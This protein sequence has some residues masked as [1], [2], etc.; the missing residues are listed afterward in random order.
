[1]Y[2]ELKNFVV[3]LSFIRML[4]AAGFP[5]FLYR[6]NRITCQFLHFVYVPYFLSVVLHQ[7]NY[8]IK[9]N[10]KEGSATEQ[11]YYQIFV[12]IRQRQSII[13][14]ILNYLT[15]PYTCLVFLQLLIGGSMAWKGQMEDVIITFLLTQN[16]FVHTEVNKMDRE[17][18]HFAN[19]PVSYQ[20]LPLFSEC[21][22]IDT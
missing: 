6:Y 1:M 10:Y 8:L 14:V 3:P 15:S 4:C 9:N 12:S 2:S 17:K 11:K 13:N 7:C 22:A 20:N 16:C 5:W 19:L 18:F 21:S